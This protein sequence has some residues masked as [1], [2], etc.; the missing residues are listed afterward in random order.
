MSRANMTRSRSTVDSLPGL[1]RPERGTH[2]AL[3]PS[4]QIDLRRERRA[5]VR[6]RGSGGNE[7][8]GRKGTHRDD[9]AAIL[10]Q[11][12]LPLRRLPTEAVEPSGARVRSRRRG[13]HA[14]ERIDAERVS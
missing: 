14:D 6:D 12:S 1:T 3:S 11:V 8:R 4:V 10:G 13:W 2:Q 9:V 5:F 7:V